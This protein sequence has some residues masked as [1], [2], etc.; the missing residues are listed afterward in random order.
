MSFSSA[1]AVVRKSLVWALF[2]LA[3]VPLDSAAFTVNVVNPNRGSTDGGTGVTITGTGFIADVTIAFGGDMAT[4][5]AVPDPFSVTATT[6][7]NAAG[8]VDVIVLNGDGQSFTLAGGF[9]YEAPPAPPAVKPTITSTL[10]AHGTVGTPFSYTIVATGTEPLEY[11]AEGLPA[12]L[13]LQGNVIS[14]TPQAAAVSTVTMTADNSAGT[15]TRPL[16]LA[17]YAATVGDTDDDHFRDELEN[18]LGTSPTSASDTPFGG[19]PAGT[20]V[21]LIGIKTAIKLNFAK[22]DSDSA[23]IQGTLGVPA[24]FI[25]QGA[26][27]VV[28]IGGLIHKL[29][30]NEKGQALTLDGKGMFKIS[31]KR[32][33]GVVETAHDA[34]FSFQYKKASIADKFQDERLLNADVKAEIRKIRYVVLFNQTYYDSLHPVWY[35]AKEDKSGA[36]K[37][38]KPT[39]QVPE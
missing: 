25:V 20:P 35:N 22:P 36:T 18:A 39:E 8:P 3:A 6:P 33:K 11:A 34:K 4:N 32:K 21:E 28:D 10:E 23:K 31:V 5:V 13:S 17:I 15:D 19:A 24:G 2:A 27:V 26:P 16:T 14:G 7:A 9:T 37:D 1:C 38:V 12:G 30:L 29:S